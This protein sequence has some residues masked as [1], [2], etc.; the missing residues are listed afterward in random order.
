MKIATKRLGDALKQLDGIT[1]IM[2]ENKPTHIDDV[3]LG[4]ASDEDLINLALDY[5]RVVELD[6]ET[7]ESVAYFLARRLE[8]KVFPSENS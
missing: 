2:N 5:D 4:W 1:A 3:E 7:L 8:D 6:R